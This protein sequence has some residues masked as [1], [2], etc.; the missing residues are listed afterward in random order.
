MSLR[1]ALL[2]FSLPLLAFLFSACASSGM[3]TSLPQNVSQETKIERKMPYFPATG[4]RQIDENTWFANN[5][6]LPY[7]PEL[8]GKTLTWHDAIAYNKGEFLAISEAIGNNLESPNVIHIDSYGRPQFLFGEDFPQRFR[9]ISLDAQD[10]GVGDSKEEIALVMQYAGKESIVVI[11]SKSLKPVFWYESDDINL[12]TQK[13]GKSIVGITFASGRPSIEAYRW[14]GEKYVKTEVPKE[15]NLTD[16]M[17]DK[18]EQNKYDLIATVLSNPEEGIRKTQRI[19][20]TDN[21]LLVSTALQFATRDAYA[22]D[23]GSSKPLWQYFVE[24]SVQPREARGRVALDPLAA[25]L[26]LNKIGIGQTPLPWADNE[27]LAVVVA[28][29]LSEESGNTYLNLRLTRDENGKFKLE[30][31]I[32]PGERLIKVM[33]AAQVYAPV[34]AEDARKIQQSLGSTAQQGIENLKEIFE[35]ADRRGKQRQQE[36]QRQTDELKRSIG[37]KAKKKGEEIKEDIKSTICDN[38][39]KFIPKPEACN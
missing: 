28:K 22:V 24:Y 16:K 5:T 1:S 32:E 25:Y 15:L 31:A 20:G 18:I 8:E 30:G 26:V 19:L 29:N 9:Q 37:E 4:Y 11:D 2:K 23:E 13:N 35:A 21:P 3:P 38:L 33:G 39:P 7:M 36:S 27:S 17:V 14:N 34:A 6:G 12:V 10:Y